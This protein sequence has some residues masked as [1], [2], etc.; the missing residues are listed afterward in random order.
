MFRSLARLAPAFLLAASCRNGSSEDRSPV[1][2]LSFPPPQAWTEA[3]SILV[4]GTADDP[5]G[6]AEVRVDGA[7]AT[8]SDGFATWRLSVPLAPGWNALTVT[9]TSRDGSTVSRVASRIDSEPAISGISGI[10]VVPGQERAVLL[11][12][13][14]L[15]E[16]DLATGIRRIASDET[17]GTGPDIPLS[18]AI[19]FAVDRVLVLASDGGSSFVL[20]VDPERGDRTILS[21]DAHGVGPA[22]A[23]GA[24]AFDGTRALVVAAAGDG[25]VAIDLATGDRTSLPSGTGT[26]VVHPAGLAVDGDRAFAI[27]DD[28]RAVIGFDL[29]TGDRVVVSDDDL[30]SGPPFVDAASIA[31]DASGLLVADRW[32]GALF[33]VDASTG[34][35]TILSDATTGSGPSMSGPAAVTLHGGRALVGVNASVLSVDLDSGARTAMTSDVEVGTGPRLPLVTRIVASGDR[36]VAIGES[37]TSDVVFPLYEV[38]LAHGTRRLVSDRTRGSG[39]LL[40]AVGGIAVD[41]PRA[42]VTGSD[43]QTRSAVLAVDRSS[44]NRSILSGASRGSGPALQ[45][46]G[47]IVVDGRRALVSSAGTVDG[48]LLVGVDLQSGDRTLLSGPSVGAGPAFF[49]CTA[50]TVDDGNAFLIAHGTNG[51]TLFRVDLQ[52]GDRTE[53]SSSAVGTGPLLDDAHG[54]AVS[55]SLAF[56]TGWHLPGGDAVVVVDLSTGNRTLLSDA[57]TGGA[58]YLGDQSDIVLYRGRALVSDPVFQSILALDLASGQRVVASR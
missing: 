26:S 23:A 20:A 33:R 30:G 27:E 57:F 45:G 52:T 8:T 44:G 38:D 56:M 7:L 19:A 2:D 28:T 21:D 35:R 39:P 51:T 50:L 12:G 47:P 55:G 32:L 40:M 15:L 9:A 16:M 31:V 13:D 1:V 18:A 54:L 5:A 43:D 3:G 41:G 10:A 34:D 48:A 29:V 37:T 46:Q 25:L 49:V 17:H 22:F 4:S 53:V 42:L 24:I 36:L 11:D 58:P 14:R 6:I